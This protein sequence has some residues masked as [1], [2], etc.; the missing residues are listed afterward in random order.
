MRLSIKKYAFIALASASLILSACGGASGPS[1]KSGE[2]LFTYD[3]DAPV[4]VMYDLSKDA[5]NINIKVE[6]LKG[7]SSV[8]IGR[9]EAEK[10]QFGVKNEILT[11]SGAFLKEN[12]GS[13][14]KEIVVTPKEGRAIKIPALICNCIITTP[15]EFQDINNNLDG[16]YALGNDIDF[17]G[18]GNFE[19][20]GRYVSETDTSNHYFHGILEGNGYAIKNLSA[21][22]SQNPQ[23]A[24]PADATQIFDTN[25]DVYNGTYGFKDEAHKNG[26]NIGV[27]QIIGSSGIVRNMVFDN[28]H[29]R[30]RTIV[31]VVAG[32]LAGTVQNVLIKENC[33]AEMNTHFYDNDCNIGGA[34]GIVGGSGNASNC[35]SLT[36]NVRVS[37]LYQD[38]GPDY[39]GKIGNGWDHSAAQGNTDNWWRFVSVDRN[40]LTDTG[41]E[42]DSNNSETNGVYSFVGKC[43][44][45]VSNSVSYSFSYRPYQN[46]IDRNAFFGQTHLAVNKPTSGDTNLGQLINCNALS[47]DAL[48]QASNY[49]SFDTTIWNITDG[50]FPSL[51]A[52]QISVETVQ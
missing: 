4:S 12:V 24:N 51:V 18:F 7:A 29:V 31:G 42:K 14:E 17:T 23:V 8:K 33:I 37:G 28:V 45:Q 6:G 25:Q 30:G 49:A 10:N 44:G 22:Y 11:L 35:V 32:N 9:A 46:T 52:P 34:F 47:L 38:Y 50:S 41:K 21:L 13:G 2:A 20:L 5:Y 1:P 16:T 27:F 48:K 3:K 43:W 36:G 26:D 40:N 19:P 15:Q 39:A